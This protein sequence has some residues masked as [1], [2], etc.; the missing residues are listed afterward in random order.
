MKI[1]RSISIVIFVLTYLAQLNDGKKSK[2]L[3][4]MLK[5]AE[6]TIANKNEINIDSFKPIQEVKE[7]ETCKPGFHNGRINSMAF[8]YKG[9]HGVMTSGEA[10]AIC[11]SD[12][13]CGGFTFYGSKGASEK[14]HFVFFVHYIYFT[15]KGIYSENNSMWTSYR[16]KK[17]VLILPGK[18]HLRRIKLHVKIH[19]DILAGNDPKSWAFS[20]EIVSVSYSKTEASGQPTFTLQDHDFKAT[21][22]KTMIAYDEIHTNRVYDGNTWDL[23]KSCHQY[24]KPLE[25]VSLRYTKELHD[26]IDTIECDDFSKKEVHDKYIKLGTPVKIK[27]CKNPNSKIKDNFNWQGLVL[28]NGASRSINVIDIAESERRRL[29][30]NG[31]L[32]NFKNTDYEFLSENEAIETKLHEDFLPNLNTNLFNEGF[33]DT[34]IETNFISKGGGQDIMLG[35]SKERFSLQING[36]KWWVISVPGLVDPWQCSTYDLDPFWLTASWF[37]SIQPQLVSTRYYGRKVSMTIQNPGEIIYIPS[38][39]K[40]TNYAI[41]DSYSMVKSLQSTGGLMEETDSLN[42]GAFH[43]N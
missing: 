20:D 3:K 27:G 17:K 18:P 39:C 14:K 36:T 38:N 4:E 11:E 7:C 8:E 30:E 32:L 23:K 41:E 34:A 19:E 37:N 22:W 21:G 28:Q 15:K 25:K 42:L 26:T 35:A 5:N 6:D 29:V 40:Y 43:I 24:K 33:D 16:S 2:K 31:F 1:W 10:V 12:T 13:A 9:R